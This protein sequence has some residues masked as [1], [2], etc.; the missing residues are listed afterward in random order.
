MTNLATL[1]ID[2]SRP[3]AG[4]ND[5]TIW[6]SE[7]RHSHERISIKVGKNPVF[8]GDSRRVSPTYNR[9]PYRFFI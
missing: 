7:L 3:M 1:E 9:Q 4:N 8:M 2:K 6:I 5:D